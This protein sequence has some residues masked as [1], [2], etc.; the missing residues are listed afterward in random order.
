MFVGKLFPKETGLVGD[1]LLAFC[2]L[3]IYFDFFH[4][5]ICV[6]ESV[7]VRESDN[8]CLRVEHRR[9]FQRF[10]QWKGWLF[11][12]HMKLKFIHASLQMPIMKLDWMFS[13]CKLLY[14]YYSWLS[15][16]AQL[17]YLV[18][19]CS[20]VCLVIDHHSDTSSK[21]W[22]WI[23]STSWPDYQKDDEIHTIKIVKI[24]ITCID[25]NL[26]GYLFSI[27]SPLH[28]QYTLLSK[29]LYSP[30]PKGFCTYLCANEK[31]LFFEL[32][33]SIV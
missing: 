3:W 2:F 23:M 19:S 6:R 14:K 13:D 4:V 1:I 33:T 20:I 15:H 8:G 31:M 26:M 28:L 29:I 18:T 16:I 30:P 25:F 17:S 22:Q 7:C 10:N 5:Y 21:T 24:P 11:W 12:A 9:W 27:L 32:S